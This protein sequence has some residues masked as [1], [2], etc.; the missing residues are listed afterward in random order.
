[1]GL[2]SSAALALCLLRAAGRACGRPLTDEEL[3]EGAW[4]LERLF[5][6]TPS[7][8]DHT[9]SLRGGALLFRRPPPPAAP[10]Y[11][12]VALGAPLHLRVLHTPRAGDT[13]AAVGAV[14][15]W[16][17]AHPAESA[18]R[19]ER[20]GALAEEGA[21]ALRA[22]DARALGALMGEAHAH[23]AALGVSTPALEGLRAALL[24]SGALGA[25]LTG[26]GLGGAVVGVFASG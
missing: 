1:V 17:A 23:L 18:R 6:G 20:M 15:A 21:A 16:A 2:G 25:K 4:E 3:D 26:A 9:V 8:L 10:T 13:A 11:A 19:F 7:G 14:R 22:G 5:H 24:A 12:P